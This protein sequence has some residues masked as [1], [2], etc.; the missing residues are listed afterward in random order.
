[1]ARAVR[2]VSRLLVA[3]LLMAVGAAMLVLPGPGLLT[4]AVGVG[5]AGR[6]LGW[7]R[8]QRWERRVWSWVHRAARGPRRLVSGMG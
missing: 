6:E 2:R 7:R 1:M 3:A 8:V 5:I 4:I